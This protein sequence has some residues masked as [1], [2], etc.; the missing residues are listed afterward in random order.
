MRDLLVAEMERRWDQFPGLVQVNDD[1]QGAA[2]IQID[3]RRF[4][5]ALR[6]ERTAQGSAFRVDPWT[7]ELAARAPECPRSVLAML[8]DWAMQDIEAG[9]HWNWPESPWDLLEKWG[10]DEVKLTWSYSP[11][12][13]ATSV[14]LEA[15]EPGRWLPHRASVQVARAVRA[16]LTAGSAIWQTLTDLITA[17]NAAIL[18]AL[19]APEVTRSLAPPGVQAATTCAPAHAPPAGA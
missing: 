9:G 10:H 18:R 8:F 3:W 11:E 17:A 15:E 12:N 2:R 14:Q 13:H 5:S 16:R 1:D 7:F 19:T 4:A 6:R